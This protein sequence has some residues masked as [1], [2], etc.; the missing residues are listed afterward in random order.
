MFAL[1]RSFYYKLNDRIFYYQIFQNHFILFGNYKA[2]ELVIAHSELKIDVMSIK[3][4]P[5]YVLCMREKAAACQKN[6]QFT[7]YR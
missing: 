2:V 6:E 3:C 4:I 7:I 5:C 1:N